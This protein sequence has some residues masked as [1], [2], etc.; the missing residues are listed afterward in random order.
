M[1]V[2]WGDGGVTISERFR[3]ALIFMKTERAVRR[4]CDD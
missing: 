2:F 3:E 4:T 1:S